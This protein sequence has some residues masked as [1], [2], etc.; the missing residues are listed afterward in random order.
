MRS[1]VCVL[2]PN[3]EIEHISICVL[4]LSMDL[5]GRLGG[6]MLKNKYNIIK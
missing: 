6:A 2:T 4:E 1:S 3:T 5:C